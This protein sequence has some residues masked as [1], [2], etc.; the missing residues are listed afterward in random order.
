[1]ERVE[2]AEQIAVDWSEMAAKL[3][4]K[5]NEE[6]IYPGNDLLVEWQEKTRRALRYDRDYNNLK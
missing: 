6:G 1:M 2:R 4:D 5:L 3:L